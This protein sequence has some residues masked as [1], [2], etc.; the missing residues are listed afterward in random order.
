MLRTFSII[1]VCLLSPLLPSQ[2]AWGQDE[3][4]DTGFTLKVVF[5]GLIA[6]VKEDSHVWALLVNAEYDPDDQKESDFPHCVWE[7]ISDAD[8]RKEEYPP[9]YAYIHFINAEVQGPKG[10]LIQ[11]AFPIKEEDIRILNGVGAFDMDLEELGSKDEVEHARRGKS[12][13]DSVHRVKK[14]LLDPDYKTIIEQKEILAARVLLRNGEK[15]IA[16]P[17]D[18]V[19]ENKPTDEEPGMEEGS[20]GEM[21]PYSYLRYGEGRDIM[22]CSRYQGC[23][24]AEITTL[25]QRIDKGPAIFYLQNT[26]QVYLVKPKDRSKAVT[27]EILN[28]TCED[29]KD[30]DPERD[31]QEVGSGHRH[32][33]S[34]RYFY[35]LAESRDRTCKRYFFPCD[36]VM[37]VGRKCPQ[38]ELAP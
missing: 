34:Y 29:V 37:A 8:E 3:E 31:C 27:V 25:E 33:M 18:R 1:A 4:G 28:I 12:N 21:K 16:R 22:T 36:R 24:L 20:H 14:K 35:D 10:P 19:K 5:D 17:I 11:K 7:E 38:M 2:V 6:F 9:H 26:N 23:E 30:I 15:L 13:V 32:L